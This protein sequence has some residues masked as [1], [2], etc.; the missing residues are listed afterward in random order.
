VE[1]PRKPY[2]NCIQWKW[3]ELFM[4]I[5]CGNIGSY[6]VVLIKTIQMPIESENFN[7]F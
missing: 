2:D 3:F 4:S 6:F 7:G 5:S 1:P